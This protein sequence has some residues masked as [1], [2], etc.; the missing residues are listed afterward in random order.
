MQTA[1]LAQRHIPYHR[2]EGLCDGAANVAPMVTLLGRLANLVAASAGTISVRS[3][4]SEL[5]V[6]RLGVDSPTLPW[7]EA[8]RFGKSRASDGLALEDRDDA[9]HLTYVQSLD[10]H[11]TIR[12]V[13][14]RSVTEAP[15]SPLD[16]RKVV[17][18]VPWISDIMLLWWSARAVSV[19]ARYME[20]AFDALA[21]GL[22]VVGR[23]CRVLTVNP[24]GSQA[25][26]ASNVLAISQGRL[27]ANDLHDDIR[28]KTVVF[29]SATRPMIDGQCSI[30]VLRIKRAKQRPL[31]LALSACSAA[32]MDEDAVLVQIV[33]PDLDLAPHIEVACSIHGITGAEARLA[34]LLVAGH[35]LLEAAG[36]LRVQPDTARSYL[37]QMFLK[38][39]VNRQAALIQLLLAS[40]VRESPG[41]KLRII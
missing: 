36:H 9:T 22:V 20:R 1:T 35:S 39:G 17:G 16:L 18:V 25:M 37:K 2:I 5:C 10:Q 30:E 15:L 28:L 21:M 40:M 8:A 33:D 41:S 31:I 6:A 38:T 29:H 11:C 27:A 26:A 4:E 13:L 3:T 7:P 12:V 23:E 24:A 32:S 14:S 19:F 34:R